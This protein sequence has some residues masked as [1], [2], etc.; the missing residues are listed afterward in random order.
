MLAA[1]PTFPVQLAAAGGVGVLHTLLGPDHYLPLLAITKASGWSLRRALLVTAVAGLLHCGASALLLPFALA[2]TRAAGTLA[3]V[4]DLRATVA[5]WLVVGLGL[6]LLGAAFR[7]RRAAAVAPAAAPAAVPGR[8][9][10]RA[11][12]LLAFAVG[13][14]EWL[15]PNA[16][17]AAGTAGAGGALAVSLV[18]TASTVATML[19]VVA[20]S[21]RLLPAQRLPPLR[22]ALLGGASVLACGVA[23]LAGA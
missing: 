3:G 15:L 16:L 22:F 23:M 2:A 12:L 6:A 8:S 1:D 10:A 7:A 14:C 13:P 5:A 21:L 9:G 17:T 18:F 11:L 20:A 19:A 4:Q